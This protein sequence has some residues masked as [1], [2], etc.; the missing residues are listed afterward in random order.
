MPTDSRGIPFGSC[1]S[2]KGRQSEWLGGEGH[3][4]DLMS[5]GRALWQ[6][7]LLGDYENAHFRR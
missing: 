4:A 3:G 7:T 2:M 6:F 5:R 1:D